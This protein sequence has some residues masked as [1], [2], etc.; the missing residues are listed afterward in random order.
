MDFG[1]RA[2]HETTVAAKATIAK[3]YGEGPQRSLY[4]SCSTGGRIGLMEAYRYPE[5]YDGISAIA[6]ANPMVPLMVMSLWTGNATM[7]DDTSR[8]PPPKYAL[9]QKAAMEACD[10]DD[11]VRDGIIGNP[12]TCGFDPAMLQCNGDDAE[13]T[14]CLTAPQVQAMREIYRGPRNSRTGEEIYPASRLAQKRRCR[15]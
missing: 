12:P 1:H 9:V 14:D 8:I 13:R 11:G 10:V 3:F 2:V 6:P 7:K 15:R 5:D 4:A